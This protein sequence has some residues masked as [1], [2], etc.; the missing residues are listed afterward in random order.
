MSGYVYGEVKFAEYIVR[1][2]LSEFHSKHFYSDKRFYSDLTLWFKI[3]IWKK[4]L[5][6]KH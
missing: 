1:T 6:L 4:Y 5:E 2:S 3:K